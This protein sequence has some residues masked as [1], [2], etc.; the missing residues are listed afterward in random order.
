MAEVIEGEDL[1]RL[2]EFTF[3]EVSK[4][5]DDASVIASLILERMV[6]FSNNSITVTKKNE[7]FEVFIYLSKDKKR[8]LGSTSNLKEESLKNF[9]DKLI[10]ACESSKESEDYT[11]LEK[12][13]LP[14][15]E[16]Y[17]FDERIAKGYVDLV[18]LANSGINSAL[19]W[20]NRVAGSLLSLTNY[21]YILT[22]SGVERD[23][24]ATQIT[25]NIRA[26]T[27]KEISG[28]G[29][30]CSSNSRGLD[31]EKAGRE[32]G[33][34]ALNS[35]RRGN[36]E[37]GKYEV[38]YSP[39]VSADLFQHIGYFSSAYA[40]EIGISFLVDKLDS[41]VAVEDFS[42]SDS[43][44]VYGALNSRVFDDEG[45]VSG[46]TKIIE[47]GLLKGYL[48]N[49]TTAKKFNT[50]STGNAGII[51][52]S[53]WNLIVEGGNSTYDDMVKSMKKGL[54]VTNN[55]YTRFQ[56]LREGAFSTLPRDATYLVEDGEIKHSIAGLRITDSLPRMLKEI[57]E[58]SKERRWIKWWEV[59]I[60]VLSPW[61]KVKDV[62]ITKAE[63]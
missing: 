18:D 32:A 40:I 11:P 61:V 57:D 39:T 63:G 5:V 45:Y 19:K 1:K 55:W 17:N 26:F 29:L 34:H 27:E 52:P 51:E 48:H 9:I 3:K 59:E 8:F 28:H 60:P 42:L 62:L 23:D 31:V 15:S 41:K 22:T 24:K 6:R 44:L 10:K 4:R 53:P 58:M 13:P 7:N 46:N 20:A 37:E 47:K 54:I 33:E 14:F 50:K 30:S 25:I 12:A 16:H 49:L 56:N 21:S 36:W 43:A 2:G 38:L 35:K